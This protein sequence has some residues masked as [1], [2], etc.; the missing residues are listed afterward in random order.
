MSEILRDCPDAVVLE[1]VS[2]DKNRSDN[3]RRIRAPI[4]EQD[5]V[6]TASGLALTGKRVFVLAPD[7]PLYVARGYEQIRASVAVPGVNVILSSVQDGDLLDRDGSVRQ[8]NEDFALMRLLPNMAVLA[9]SDKRCAYVLAHRLLERDGPAY[10]RLSHADVPNIYEDDDSNFHVGGARLISEG[11]GVTICAN[12]VMVAEAVKASHILAQQGIMAEIIDCY[13][14]KPFPE[15]A[16]LSSVRRTGCCVVAEKHADVAGLYGAV[17]ECLCEN[18]TVPARSVAIE[19]DFGQSGTPDELQ[20]YYGLT[21]REIVHNVV[22][23]W[24]MRRR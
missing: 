11:D 4:A 10:V 17:A 13:S 22:Q 21:H 19:G 15:Q 1:S 7:L 3:S 6:L 5:M 24:A 16:L 12:G 2:G 8:M 14:I 23:V 20:E 9:P 18:Y